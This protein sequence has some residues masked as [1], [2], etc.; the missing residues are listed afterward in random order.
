MVSAILSIVIVNTAH[1]LLM[2]ILGA[3]MM[4]Y[5]WKDK[6]VWYIIVWL[7]LFC[8]IGI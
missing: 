5:N 8:T 6:V 7:L 1:K 2:W 3:R 4:F